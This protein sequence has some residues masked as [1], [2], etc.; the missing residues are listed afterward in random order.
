MSLFLLIDKHYTANIKH[1]ISLV[2]IWCISR[3]NIHYYRNRRYKFYTTSLKAAIAGKSLISAGLDFDRILHFVFFFSMINYSIFTGNI[4]PAYF[5]KRLTN[6][7]KDHSLGTPLLIASSNDYINVFWF[8]WDKFHS[9]SISIIFTL[10]IN[11][12]LPLNIFTFLLF[13]RLYLLTRFLFILTCLS[14]V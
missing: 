12:F 13:F 11:R 5:V 9:N 4:G 10:Y 3:L 1:M 2:K 6:L 14:H 7:K 8:W